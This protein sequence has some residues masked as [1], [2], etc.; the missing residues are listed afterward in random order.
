MG[1]AH[2]QRIRVSSNEA[3]SELRAGSVVGLIEVMKTFTHLAYAPAAS[4]PA[5]AR[6]ARV[7]VGDGDEVTEGDPLLE[8][9]PA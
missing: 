6:V 7:L 3:G 8:V 9:E 1:R 5:N 2:D 4:L